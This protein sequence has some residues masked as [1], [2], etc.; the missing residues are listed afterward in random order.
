M[1]HSVHF[2]VMLT[3][4]TDNFWVKTPRTIKISNQNN[5]SLQK[6][7]FDVFLKFFDKKMS[8]EKNGVFD[9]VKGSAWEVKWLILSI[10]VV[11]SIWF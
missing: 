4:L 1:T 3:Q 11:V 2:G 10:S 7:L 6:N 5:F 9:N 8:F